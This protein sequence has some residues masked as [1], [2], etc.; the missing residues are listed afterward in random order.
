MK[1]S[2]IKVEDILV[3][4]DGFTCLKHGEKSIVRQDNK[5]LYINCEEG[6]H[7]LEGQIDEEDNL[8]GLFK[9]KYYFPSNC[10]YELDFLIFSLLASIYLYIQYIRI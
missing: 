7:Y 4:D 8:I 5:G 9:S 2:E 1:L 3:F 6:K 10:Y